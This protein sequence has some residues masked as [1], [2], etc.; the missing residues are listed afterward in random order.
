ADV[1][2]FAV[3]LVA[4]IL[5]SANVLDVVAPV[6]GGGGAAARRVLPF[7]L[8]RQPIV[9]PSRMLEPG[10][11]GADFD[12]VHADDRIAFGL[13]ET[14]IFPSRVRLRL[15]RAVGDRLTARPGVKVGGLGESDELGLGD[16]E[17][18][19]CKRFGEGHRVLRLSP[20]R[21]VDCDVEALV[22]AGRGTHLEGAGWDDHHLGTI[23]A[24]A[25]GLRRRGAGRALG[26]GRVCRRGGLRPAPRRGGRAGATGAWVAWAGGGGGGLGGIVTGWAAGAAAV[27]TGGEGLF[28]GHSC[29]ARPPPAMTTTATPPAI[30]AASGCRRG[31]P[32][33]GAD[34]A[35]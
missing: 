6:I 4:D 32:P 26:R 2:F 19:E 15:P 24:I 3:R 12:R 20:A 16:V 1:V 9:L 28:F 23:G 17:F 21:L 31:A 13:V 7:R 10:D 33:T 14:R 30:S 5:V 18:A 22:L 8:G 34:T 27:V 11:V 29:Q 25:E 35:A